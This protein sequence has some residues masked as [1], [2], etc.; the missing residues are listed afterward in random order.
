MIHR[1]GHKFDNVLV[2]VT[3]G[4]RTKMTEQIRRSDFESMDSQRWSAFHCDL[5]IRIT[6]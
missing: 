5:R 1:F 3:W 4:W 6:G 2:S